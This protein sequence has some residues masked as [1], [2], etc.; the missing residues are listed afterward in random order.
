MILG[1]QNSIAWADP[2]DEEE[3]DDD[4]NHIQL[5][6]ITW[7]PFNLGLNVTAKNYNDN[8]LLVVTSYRIW[9][10]MRQSLWI[11]M[12]KATQVIEKIPVA[13]IQNKKRETRHVLGNR[14]INI[15]WR[16]KKWEKERNTNQFNIITTTFAASSSRSRKSDIILINVNYNVHV[17]NEKQVI[18]NI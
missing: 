4:F 12:R 6:P 11:S 7:H 15:N 1:I 14:L 18:T 3:Q 2:M 16:E 10:S 17:V 5:V 9:L 13:V 8:L